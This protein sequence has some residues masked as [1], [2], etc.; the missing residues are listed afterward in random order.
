MTYLALLLTGLL[1]LLT[2]WLLAVVMMS[3][4]LASTFGAIL[5]R[6]DAE[7]KVTIHDQSAVFA[8]FK[9]AGGR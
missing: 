5:K 1:A 7:G 6:L 9:K 2:G 8:A 4:S 3:R